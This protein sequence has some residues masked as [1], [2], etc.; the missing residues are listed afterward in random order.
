[1]TKK[2]AMVLGLLL[3]GCD[4]GPKDV[5]Y[6]LKNDQKRKEI[7][8]RCGFNLFSTAEKPDK[9]D[10]N[11]AE[12]AQTQIDIYKLT[13]NQDSKDYFF[14]NPDMRE[15][16]IKECGSILRDKIDLTP[17]T[18]AFNTEKDIQVNILKREAKGLEK[19]EDFIR[20]GDRVISSFKS[21]CRMNRPYLD[22]EPIV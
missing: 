5:A 14:N 19:V 11:N 22:Q 9:Q 12:A 13:G 16:V 1:M 2:Y 15:D 8:D 10:C 21:H 18:N 17:C 4:S 20:G 3:A 7:L 6:Y